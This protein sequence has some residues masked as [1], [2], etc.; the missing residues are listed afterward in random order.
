MSHNDRNPEATVYIGNLDERVT[1][2]II[3]EL[4]TQAGPVGKSLLQYIR[5][6]F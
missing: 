1:D 3:W 4:M 5:Y 6:K 2:T